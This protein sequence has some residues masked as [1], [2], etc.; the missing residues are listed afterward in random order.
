MEVGSVS[1]VLHESWRGVVTEGLGL[2]GEDSL[3]ALS[4]VVCVL[5]GVVSLLLGGNI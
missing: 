1:V 3:Q 5:L 2:G 4:S